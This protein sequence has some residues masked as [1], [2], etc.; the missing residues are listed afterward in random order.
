M[1]VRLAFAVAAHLEP[2]ILLVDEVL[3][4]GDAAFQKKCLGKMQEVTT[5]GRTVLFVSHS[6]PSILRLCP[7]AMLLTSG[8]LV[9]EGPAHDVVAAYLQSGTGINGERRW[10]DLAT[11]PGDAVTRLIAVRVRDESGR[12]LDKV[13]VRQRFGIDV[14]YANLSCGAR[15]LPVLHLFNDSG[16][17]LFASI[18]AADRQW[19]NQPHPRGYFKATCWIPANLLAEGRVTVRASVST[20]NPDAVH[21]SEWDAVAFVVVDDSVGDAARGASAVTF[22]GSFGRSSSGR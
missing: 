14:E 11:A 17:N 4:V 2:E 5:S 8:A 10:D 9:R 22:L 7:R 1:Y 6:M 15:L 3:A 13:D 19:Y 18:N 20:H 21:A 16:V 12:V